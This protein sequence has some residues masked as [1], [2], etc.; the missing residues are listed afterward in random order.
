MSEHRNMSYIKQSKRPLARTKLA[1]GVSLGTA[2]FAGLISTGASAADASQTDSI[3]LPEVS[4]NASKEA[5]VSTYHKE[6]LG[7]AKFTSPVSKTPKTIQIIDKALIEDQHATTLTEALKNSPG[8]GTFYVGENG[9]TTTG[10][11]VYMRGFDSSGSIFVDGVRDMG[12]ISRDTFNTEQVEVIKG[13]DGADYGRTAPSGSINM[14]SKQAKLGNAHS[15]TI[16]GGTDDQKRATF[17]INHQL[18]DSTALR[19]NV[20]GQDSGVPGR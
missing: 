16:S 4:V 18:G 12:A 11:S 6:T 9:N 15:G 3:A 7:S 8:V 13:P 1:S 10:D 2:L 19:V 5:T 20:M 14:V 17:D